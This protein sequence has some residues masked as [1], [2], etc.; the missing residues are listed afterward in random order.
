MGNFDSPMDPTFFSWHGEVDGVVNEWLQTENGQ[1]WAAENPAAAAPW[2]G[3]VEVD[4]APTGHRHH[5]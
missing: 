1:A 3:G 4:H 2:L 5:S